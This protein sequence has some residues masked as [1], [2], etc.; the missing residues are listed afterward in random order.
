[1]VPVTRATSDHAAPVIGLLKQVHSHVAVQALLV[2]LM[3]GIGERHKDDALVQA[4]RMLAED[5][6][7]G[8]QVRR[9]A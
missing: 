3:Q 4:G 1:V 6:L 8:A 9:S 2:G 5:A 7:T